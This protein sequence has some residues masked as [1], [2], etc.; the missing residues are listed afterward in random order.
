MKLSRSIL[1]SSV[2]GL[3]TVGAAVAADL[4]VKKAQAVEYVRVCSTYGEGF[5]YIPGTESCLK[6]GARVRADYLY[7]QPLTR[8][9][10]AF[11]FRTRGRIQL[12][13]RTETAYGLLRTF[14]RFEITRDSGTPFGVQGGFAT[15]PD[16]AQA[17]VQFGGLTAG[18]VTS[19]FDNPDLPTEH[20]GTLRFSDA[21]DVAV[22]AYTYSFGNGFSASLS[23]E[24]SQDRRVVAAP[25]LLDPAIFPDSQFLG[26]PYPLSYGGQRMPDVIGN[27]R[28]VGTW[29][30]IQVS[31]A[32]HQIRDFGVAPPMR[33]N[34]VTGAFLP[35]FGDTDYGFAATAQG[36]LNLPFISAGDTSWLALTYTDG[37]IGYI[38]GGRGNGIGAGDLFLPLTDAYI[39]PFTGD[40][41]TTKAWS[42][43]G[44]ITHNWTPEFR[45]SLFG[46]Y[47]RFEAPGAASFVVPINATTIADASAGTNVGFVDF[48]EYRIGANSFWTPVAGLNFGVEVLYA[49]IDPRGRVLIPVTNV[50]G[51]AIGAKSTSG[52]G[53]WEGR[54]RVQRDF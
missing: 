54:V 27:V 47:A 41:K 20:M 28:Y 1:L 21:P 42:I 7:G 29:G 43:A 8:G 49:K 32:A 18:K 15:F 44:G 4:P 46:S 12:D 30:T 50:A 34:P 2:V 6:I 51:N 26:A 13:H 45:S 48:N 25:F 10:D 19:F 24:D 53:I 16:V 38:L 22:F 5:F 39:D 31:G 52:E 9:N 37:A 36:S 3:A 35:A 23:A 33:T 11:G 17:F 14:V 40:E